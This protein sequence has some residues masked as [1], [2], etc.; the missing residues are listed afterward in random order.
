[1]IGGLINASICSVSCRR[2]A[3][4]LPG[5][6]LNAPSICQCRFAPASCTTV[7]GALYLTSIGKC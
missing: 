6:L 2:I 1:M 7:E 5:R 4:F 3:C